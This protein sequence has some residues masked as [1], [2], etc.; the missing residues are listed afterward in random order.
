LSKLAR[1]THHHL[2]MKHSVVLFL[3]LLAS[4][5]LADESEKALLAGPTVDRVGFPKAYA[6]T[7]Q[8]LRVVNKAGDHKVVT[9]DEA[10]LTKHLPTVRQRLTQAG[11][12]LGTLLNR[13]LG[14]E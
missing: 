11:I 14:G 13:A 3:G 12:R 9:V 4:S 1:E 6:E 5:L 10:Y 7:F 8:I 2:N